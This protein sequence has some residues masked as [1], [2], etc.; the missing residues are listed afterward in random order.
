M[1]MYL[2]FCS[3]YIKTEI[4]DSPV[5][6]RQ[7]DCHEGEALEAPGALSLLADQASHAPAAVRGEGSE[8]REGPQAQA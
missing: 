6:G 5:A 2:K 4:I 8:V 7:E 1:C 3:L